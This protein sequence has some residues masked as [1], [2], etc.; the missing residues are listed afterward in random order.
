MHVMFGSY[1]FVFQNYAISSQKQWESACG[2]HSGYFG[3]ASAAES[4]NM[5]LAAFSAF[6]LLGV[7]AL[8]WFKRRRG[9]YAPIPEVVSRYN[10]R[11]AL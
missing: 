9:T 1:S 3:I 2:V 11:H 6:M 4:M 10:L 5:L 8:A 7:F